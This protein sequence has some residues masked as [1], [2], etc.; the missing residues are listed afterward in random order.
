MT[1]DS[2]FGLLYLLPT[3]FPYIV[4]KTSKAEIYSG[5]MIDDSRIV[6][7]TVRVAKLNATYPF[8]Y[9]FCTTG[10]GRGSNW[11]LGGHVNVGELRRLGQTP[12]DK[13]VRFLEK[14]GCSLL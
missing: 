5:V 11:I 2:P 1:A 3:Q 9:G 12:A 8:P 13:I 4:T 14:G 7:I 10:A 6:T